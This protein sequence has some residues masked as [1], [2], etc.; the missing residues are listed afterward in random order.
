MVHFNRSNSATPSLSLATTVVE[1]DDEDESM[2]ADIRS[3]FCA[4]TRRESLSAMMAQED[5]DIYRVCDYLESYDQRDYDDDD[6]DAE[7]GNHLN[8]TCR[9]SICEWMYRVVDHFGVDREGKHCVMNNM[10]NA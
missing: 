5:L 10:I 7:R 3:S 9:T 6:N 1:R 8:A 4:D 2:I